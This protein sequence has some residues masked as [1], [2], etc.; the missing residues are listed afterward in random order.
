MKQQAVGRPLPLER[1]RPQQSKFMSILEGRIFEVL[2]RLCV[3]LHGPVANI[4]FFTK[5]RFDVPTL[6]RTEIF[7][8]VPFLDKLGIANQNDKSIVFECT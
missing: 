7:L 8:Q 2:E 5:A 6:P 3:Y 4:S 1:R